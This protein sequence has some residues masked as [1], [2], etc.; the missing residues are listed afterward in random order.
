MHGSRRVRK[1]VPVGITWQ[2]R[3]G[4]GH[5]WHI[6]GGCRQAKVQSAG[7]T[8]DKLCVL[9]IVCSNAMIKHEDSILGLHPWPPTSNLDQGGDER[10]GGGRDELRGSSATLEWT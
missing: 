8:N 1:L 9:R 4:S 10:T 6:Q 5:K 2:E 7:A 3:G